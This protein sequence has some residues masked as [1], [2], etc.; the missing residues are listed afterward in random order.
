MV[1]KRYYKRIEKMVIGGGHGDILI[2]AL[3]G[4]VLLIGNTIYVKNI[5]DIYLEEKEVRDEQRFQNGDRLRLAGILITF[6]QSYLIIE[7]ELEQCVF[8]LNP[9]PY[10]ET[11]FDHFPYYKKSPRI[12]RKLHSETIEVKEPPR[13]ESMAKGSLVQ[14]IVPPLCMLAVTIFMSIFMKR[15]LYVIASICMTLVTSI[16]S[17]Q[18]FFSERKEI[19]RKNNIREQVYSDYLVRLRAHVRKKRQQ[20][21]EILDYQAPPIEMLERMAIECDSRLYERSMEDEDFLQVMLGYRSG[22]S[23]ITVNYQNDELR[24]EEDEL[25]K[26][27]LQAA[28]DFKTIDQIPVTVNLRKEHLGIVGESKQIHNQLKYLMAQMCFF[29]SYHDL[30]IVFISNERCAEEFSYLRWYPHMRIQAINVVAGIYTDSIRD[31]VLGSILQIVKDR[32]QKIEESNKGIAFSPHLV[33]VIDE[34]RLIQDHAIMEYLGR[35]SKGLAISILYTTAQLARLPE[36][37]K[38]VC[39]LDNSETGRLL[40]EEGVRLNQ[41]FQCVSMESIKVEQ[42][43]RRTAAI[44]HE[45][46]MVSRIPEGITFFEM[47]HIKRPEELHVTGRWASHEAHK[48]LAVPLGVRE[49]DN[50]VELNLHEKAHGPHG[51]VAGTTGSGKSEIVQSYILSLAVNFHPY[52]VGFLLIDYKGGGMANLFQKLPHLLGTI[53]NLD[54]AESYRAMVSI[55]SELA[56]RQRIFNQYNVNH[57]NGYHQ[58]Y[59]LGKAQEAI[60][61]LFLISDEFAELKKEQPEFMK[62]LVSA[63]RIGRSLGIHLILATQKPSGVVDEQIWTNSKFKLCL[64]VQNESDSR[65]MIK[66]PDAAAITQPGRAYLQVGNNE[67]YELFQSA[68]SGAPYS[69]EESGEEERDTR[70]WLVNELGQGQ[71]INQDLGGSM[72]SN[73]IRKTQLDVVVDYI[74][75]AFDA[76]SLPMVKSPWL[77]PLGKIMVSPHLQQI[78]DSASFDMLDLNIALGME[79]IPSEQRQEEYR[80]NFLHNGHVILFASTGY[81]KTVFL[82]TILL[83]LCARNSVRNLNAYILDFGNN[84]M[85]ALKA[86]PHVADYITYDDV[87]K[88]QKLM[89][90]L[91]QEMKER[92]QLM[93]DAMAQNFDIYNQSAGKKLKAI[94]VLLDNYDVVKELGIDENFFVQL[95][96]DGANLGIYLAMTASRSSVVKYALMNQIK[97]KIAGYNYEPM[98]ARN[99]VGRSEYELPEIKGRTLVKGE[100]INLMQIYSP[101]DFMTGLEYN[102]NLQK[103]IQQIALRSTETKA[104]GIAVL[105]GQFT[106]SMLPEYETGS[107]ADITLGLEKQQVVKLGITTADT[108]FLIVGPV[109]SGKSNAGKVVLKQIKR[110][111]KVF[112]F[113]ARDYEYQE[114]ASQENVTYIDS[115]ETAAQCLEELKDLIEERKE[116]CRESR[117]RM[118]TVEFYRTLESYCIFINGLSDFAELIRESG[119]VISTMLQAVE[120]GILIVM[121]GHASHIPARSETA[122][123]VK[124]AENGLILGEFGANTAFPTIRGKDLPAALEDG[125]LYKKGAGVM[126]RIP[127]G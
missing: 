30:Q 38:T 39:I 59:K 107:T 26:E 88:Q 68:F 44:T 103:L 29:H 96:R 81:G 76:L 14:I 22:E 87:E 75:E 74:A 105:P 113:D 41:T 34:P 98:E 100:S 25:Q 69:E 119:D 104:K 90:L 79:D 66:T 73:R 8:R 72:E 35:Q 31:Q 82:E 7:G 5:T 48:S 71:L 125:L 21:R 40:M 117:G 11:P 46:G 4:E 86:L 27:A 57:I 37:I 43:S 126:I 122:K 70:V 9:Y 108:P 32:K 2:P 111:E 84:A 50:Y 127:R 54:G 77:P 94:L 55:K 85:I 115:A 95:A 106:L 45:K 109:R 64:K 67:I 3:S 110:F 33:F 16:F 83:S 19:R 114:F 65:E 116:E 97:T 1:E 28:Q 102:Q 56:R 89:R 120:T 91:M 92:K 52:E 124:A 13:K 121:V 61:H 6:F 10:K 112:L 17:I 93:A 42:M 62:E 118:N 20:E 36:N 24:T 53:T 101:V 60:P 49:Q 80:I 51:L 58:L 12:N 123:L 15:G 99:I 78:E 23:A 18:R 47:F 63:A